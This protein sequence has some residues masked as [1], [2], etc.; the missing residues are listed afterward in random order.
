MKLTF[1][2]NLEYHLIKNGFQ[3][4]EHIELSNHS[5]YRKQQFQIEINFSY[6]YVVIYY[7]SSGGQRLRI[8]D[9]KTIHDLH[10]LEKLIEGTTNQKSIK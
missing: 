2:K 7:F 8:N 9:C 4:D 6:K 3:F 10:R 1:H 5:I